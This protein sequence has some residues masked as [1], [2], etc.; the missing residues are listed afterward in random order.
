MKEELPQTRRY[1]CLGYAPLNSSELPA[2]TPSRWWPLKH[3]KG[4][5]LFN[6]K[7]YLQ[8]WTQKMKLKDGHVVPAWI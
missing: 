2:Q 5:L 4:R 6:N 1:R 3:W 8:D 7:G